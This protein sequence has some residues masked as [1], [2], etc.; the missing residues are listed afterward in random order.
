MEFGR[1]GVVMRLGMSREFPPESD[2]PKDREGRWKCPGVT[3]EER[4]N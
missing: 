4:W 1:G 2:W 3:L